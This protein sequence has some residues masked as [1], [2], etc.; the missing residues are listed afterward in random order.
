[1]RPDQVGVYGRPQISRVQ[2][3]I[4]HIDRTF[5]GR[6]I[7]FFSMRCP[8]KL[9]TCIIVYLLSVCCL[10]LKWMHCVMCTVY[11]LTK[12]W[13]NFFFFING[14]AFQFCESKSHSLCNG[15]SDFHKQ[16]QNRSWIHKWHFMDRETH[17]GSM[18]SS[19]AFPINGHPG[20]C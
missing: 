7:I 13:Y 10:K 12:H 6:S 14:S 4:W 17:N 2:S 3:E 9:G 16:K 11:R 1:M 8:A 18:D 5:Q 15:P 20:S 19:P